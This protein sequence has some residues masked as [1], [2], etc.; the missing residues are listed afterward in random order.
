MNIVLEDIDEDG[1]CVIRVKD[2]SKNWVRKYENGFDRSY[3]ALLD[4]EGRPMGVTMPTEI[5]HA[6]VQVI[7]KHSIDGQLYSA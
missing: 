6:I 2:K 7:L 1:V 4:D 5:Y 3:A